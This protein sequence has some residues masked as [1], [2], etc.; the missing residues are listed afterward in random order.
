[1]YYRKALILE[2]FLDMAKHEGNMT[3][4]FFLYV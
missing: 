4:V 1:M 2:A 3:I